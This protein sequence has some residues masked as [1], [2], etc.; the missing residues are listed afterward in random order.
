MK[1]WLILLVIALGAGAGVGNLSYLDGLPLAGQVTMILSVG[2][3]ALLR[4]APDEN[5]NT[6]PDVLEGTWLEPLVKWLIPVLMAIA[7][8]GGA[9]LVSG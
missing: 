1:R 8:A 5:Q 9:V 3:L 2:L 6:V 4:L 7:A